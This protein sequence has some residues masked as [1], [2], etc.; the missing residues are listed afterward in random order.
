MDGG[1][2]GAVEIDGGIAARLL[3]SR[4]IASGAAAA[5]NKA[6]FLYVSMSSRRMRRA[7]AE[8]AARVAAR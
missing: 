8:A 5:T 3:P 4:S 6:S 7:F 1:R 2:T